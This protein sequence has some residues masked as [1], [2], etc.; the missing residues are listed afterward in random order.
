MPADSWPR[1][2]RAKRPSSAM[3]AAAVP[4][5]G[6]RTAPKTP[7]IRWSSGA[8]VKSPSGSPTVGIPSEGPVQA[9]VPGVAQVVDRDV[10]RI[11]DPGAAL[12]GGTGGTPAG[13]L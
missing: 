11:R 13:E 5:P 3:L 1:C 9:V 6:G 8:G 7:H 12:L 4:E 2:C 10:D